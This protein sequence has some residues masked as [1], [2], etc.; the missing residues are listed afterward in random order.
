MYDTIAPYVSVKKLDALIDTLSLHRDSYLKALRDYSD[1]ETDFGVPRPT[2]D[3]II[4]RVLGRDLVGRS[5]WV[6]TTFY[7]GDSAKPGTN[8]GDPFLVEV[9]ADDFVIVTRSSDWEE[10]V[11]IDEAKG[12]VRLISMLKRLRDSL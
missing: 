12:I 8:P 3:R 9:D 1:E 5:G 6:A 7:L 2:L 10:F 11:D 4:A